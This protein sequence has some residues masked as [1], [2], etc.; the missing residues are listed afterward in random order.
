[1][2]FTAEHD[3]DSSRAEI[4]DV[5]CDP[6]FHRG[7]DLPDLSRPE[8]LAHEAD[9]TTRVVRLRYEYTGQLDPAARKILGA[10]TLTWIQE[11]RLDTSSYT[12]TLTFSAE[13][14]GNRLSGDATVALTSNDGD[15]HTRR[16]IAGDLRV[17][18]PLIGGAAE[19]RIVPGVVRRLD[20]EA[21]ALAT[22]LVARR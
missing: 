10:Q 4:V 20:V 12:G 3:F 21:A 19:R 18:V 6:E 16:S 2:H 14:G 1:V 7:L 22:E 17:R 5:L 15:A 11:L 9:G 13:R 8:V